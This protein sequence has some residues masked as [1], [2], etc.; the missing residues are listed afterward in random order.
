MNPTRRP[1]QRGMTLIEL[2]ITLAVLALFS[3]LALPSFGSRLDRQRL[4][5]AAETLAADLAEARFE[6]A[7]RGQSL[8]V[9]PNAQGGPWC[10]S[11]AT[12]PACGCGEALACQLKTVRAD[13]HPGV[14]L[15]QA[16]DVTLAPEGGAGETRVAAVLQNRRGEQ[17]QVLLSPAGRPRVCAPGGAQPRYPAC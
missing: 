3:A 12:A 11:V 13:E 10:W 4:A 8:F 17:L 16:Q 5:T 14:Q 15:L 7:R 1:R 6:A 2:A 9:T